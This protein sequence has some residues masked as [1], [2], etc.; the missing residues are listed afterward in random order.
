[1]VWPKGNFGC[2][3]LCEGAHVTMGYCRTGWRVQYLMIASISF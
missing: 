1:M 3:V 2:V